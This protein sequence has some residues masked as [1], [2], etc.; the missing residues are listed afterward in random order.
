MARHT[1]G[2]TPPSS[3]SLGGF[4]RQFDEAMAG[5]R[6]SVR[7]ALATMK[8]AAG[9]SRDDRPNAPAGGQ[10]VLEMA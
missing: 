4:E 3:G 8:M 1:F 9:A 10:R 7:S 5:T 6:R 2:W